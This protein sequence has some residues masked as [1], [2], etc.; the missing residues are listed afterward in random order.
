[1]SIQLRAA[2]THFICDGCPAIEEAIAEGS[3]IS[4]LRGKRQRLSAVMIPFK[5]T[6]VD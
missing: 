2:L 1:M 5:L 4:G 3:G 6:D